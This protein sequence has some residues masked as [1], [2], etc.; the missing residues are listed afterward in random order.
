[1]N[2]IRKRAGSRVAEVFSGICWSW[3]ELQVIGLFKPYLDLHNR[4]LCIIVHNV[5]NTTVQ[6]MQLIKHNTS[7]VGLILKLVGTGTS[8]YKYILS[9]DRNYC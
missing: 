9:F 1:V 3:W 2:G 6:N 4:V 5:H 8:I 7:G